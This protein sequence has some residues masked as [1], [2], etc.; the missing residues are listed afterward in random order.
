[1][2]RA[3]ALRGPRLED[4]KDSLGCW[5]RSEDC[6]SDL[7]C[8]SNHLLKSYTAEEHDAEVRL[9]LRLIRNYLCLEGLI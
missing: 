5:F 3:P 9:P 2:G 6:R 8:H 4:L 7:D 1:M